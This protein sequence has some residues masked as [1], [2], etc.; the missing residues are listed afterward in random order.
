MVGISCLPEDSF[1]LAYEGSHDFISASHHGV[2]LRFFL[3]TTCMKR[4]KDRKKNINII[5]DKL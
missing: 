5:G 4:Q 3:R 2:E 1:G